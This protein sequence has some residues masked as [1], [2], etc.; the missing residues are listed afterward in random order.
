MEQYIQK[1]DIKRL[2]KNPPNKYGPIALYWWEY[3]K[4][5]K[6]K[7]FFQ[8]KE[9]KEKG[10]GGL[11]LFNQ[12]FSGDKGSSIPPYFSKKWWEF[13]RLLVKKLSELKMEFWFASWE[14]LGY[15][16][17][18]LK[19]EVKSNPELGGQCL[20]LY[21]LE[22]NQKNKFLQI[23]ISQ[24]EKIIDIAAYKKN[25]N[26]L[27][28][29]S[30]IN[31]NEVYCENKINWQAP[32]KG[33][34]LTIIVGSPYDFDFVNGRIAEKW[35]EL[36]WQQFV[37]NLKPYIG[38]TI[39]GHTSDEL[40]VLNGNILFSQSI[41]DK[42][43]KFKD[44]DIKPFLI[45]LFYNVGDITEKI[46][47]TYYE[48][49]CTSIEDN[50]HK[51][52]FKWHEERGM[53]YST[54]ATWGRGDPLA[55]T[56]H[57]GNFFSYMRNFHATGNEDA[58]YGKS[59][60]RKFIDD[61]ISSS[62]AN[63]YNLDRAIVCGY[64]GSGWGMT[65][66]QNLSW[67][68]EI[69]SY[70]MN[71]YYWPHAQ[72]TL[73]GG[74]F[75]MVPP[76]TC[77]FQPYWQHW[78]ILSD[79]IKRLSYL[80]RQ[81]RH[82]ADVAI[83]YPITNF[84]ANWSG[85]DQFTAFAD[86]SAKKICAIAKI[87][88][89]YGFDFDFI[90]DSLLEAASVKNG[91]LVI[92]N[93]EF[94]VLIL[95]PITTIRTKT[96][97]KI[98]EFFEN[99]G[100]VIGYNTLPNNSAENGINDPYIGLL[101]DRIFGTKPNNSIKAK[102]LQPESW[103]TIVENKNENNGK[104]V[105][106][107]G[108][109]PLIPE[110]INLYI[111]ADVIIQE[112][113]DIYHSNQQKPFKIGISGYGTI[114]NKQSGI[115]H[116]HRKLDFMDIYFLF[117]SND[118]EACLD[119]IFEVR[120][121]PE[122]WDLYTGEMKKIYRYEILNNGTKI[123]LKMN[124]HEGLIIIFNSN[125]HKD[126]QVVLDN[127]SVI[128]NIIN[129]DGKVAVKGFYKNG[130]RKKVI[131]NNDGIEYVAESLVIDPP[132]PLILKNEWDF[133]II[134]TMHNLWGDFRYPASNDCIGPE[135]RFFKYYKEK[136]NENGLKLKWYS[137][138][139][140]DSA[141]ES[142]IY[143]FGPY[144]WHLGPFDQDNEPA[145]LLKDI[146][147]NNISFNNKYAHLNKI[148]KWDFY[149]FSLDFGNEDRAVHNGLYYSQGLEGVS[150]NFIVFP[151]NNSSGNITHLLYTN[152]IFEVEKEMIIDFGDKT[153]TRESDWRSKEKFIFKREAWLN[154]NKIFDKNDTNFQKKVRFGKGSN[155]LV[156]KFIQEKGKKIWTYIDI[157]DLNEKPN[158]ELYVPKLKWFINKKDFIYD[159]TP[160]KKDIIGWY[161]FN[162]PP[163]L[164]EIGVELKVKN[165]DC[166]IDGEKFEIADNRVILKKPKLNISKVV[167]RVTHKPGYYAGAAVRN[168]FVFKC[169][170]TK[171]KLRNWEE[172]ALESFSGG[173]LYENSFELNSRHLNGKVIV[174]LG[175]IMVSAEL[176]I[177]DKKVGVKVM[178]PFR[179]DI[180]DHIKIGKNK[181]QVKVYNT[182]ANHY[183]IGYPTQYVFEN[184]TI[185]GLLGPVIINFFSNITLNAIKTDGKEFE[186]I[187]NSIMPKKKKWL[188]LL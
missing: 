162:A 12:Y 188:G 48:I 77:F 67:T 168:P 114:P 35:I 173:A 22:S 94:K 136:E 63:L 85:G 179:F 27:D 177:N 131:I 142:Y 33:W 16:Q 178:K 182:L 76:V 66:E 44:F 169:L 72:Y 141:W 80:L 70:G 116:N 45:A 137:K 9:L 171:V 40:Y 57:Y 124:S 167:F 32:E 140:E 157:F 39:T 50:F 62:I 176:I 86:F 150:E 88:Y 132:E 92:N 148:Y 59:G 14:S 133:E 107:P 23:L 46:R 69:Y 99:G 30:R 74:W 118:K 151:E 41:L 121:K 126:F 161:R 36:Y 43:I 120:G 129:K 91:K 79:Y 34:V 144:F 143:T 90:D 54:D 128:D 183:N 18:V 84:H 113:T 127:L 60:D 115:L 156:L 71:C 61:K 160:S 5:E 13:V 21:E 185:S 81:G 135:A 174:D 3:G 56:Y 104:S 139:F 102:W 100:T 153:E 181:I 186:K 1:K 125:E 11:V 97:E 51:K 58:G 175:E 89:E 145:D 122:L 101:V 149:N 187:K 170:K 8:L 184:Q 42:C 146:N 130:G 123:R 180:T 83:L 93:L 103:Y 73:M 166:W 117:N 49:M 110:L 112:S 28:Y 96:L 163:G 172:Y 106:I 47:C 158:Q 164:K 95:P 78:A 24:D 19:K 65:L 38:K 29:N 108:A 109:E 119:V 159:I 15:W 31:L 17:D 25:N 53:F 147:K 26:G 4:I 111:N 55:Q 75:E 2:F 138:E 134:P 155:V 20:K 6:E 154:G 105:Y 98:M 52:L 165:Y 64:W 37:K 87:I 10:I 82:C 68:N 7:L 152:I